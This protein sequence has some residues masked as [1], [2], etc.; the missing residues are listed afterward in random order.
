MELDQEKCYRICDNTLTNYSQM[1]SRLKRRKFVISVMITYYSIFLVAFPLATKYFP[2]LFNSS[3]VDYISI[4]LSVCILACSLILQ[5]VKYPERISTTIE[6]INN[7]K[8]LKREISSIEADKMDALSKT[9]ER[10]Q[11]LTLNA[12]QRDELDFYHALICR[13]A[14]YNVNPY[15]GDISNEGNDKERKQIEKTIERYLSGQHAVRKHLTEVNMRYLGFLNVLE[16]I[17]YCAVFTF[18]VVFIIISIF[19]R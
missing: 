11:A 2:Q 14:Q 6:L 1:I 18:P 10:Y 3:I 4:C 15:T 5:N 7:L 9:M 12:E 16:Y 13:S 8:D 17:S 19:R